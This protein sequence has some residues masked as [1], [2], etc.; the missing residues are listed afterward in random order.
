M[1][2][3]NKRKIKKNNQERRLI[4]DKDLERNIR[5]EIAKEQS[6]KDRNNKEDK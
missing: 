2:V 1:A 4:S 5:L 6:V 3:N